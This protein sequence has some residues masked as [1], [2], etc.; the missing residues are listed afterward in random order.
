MGSKPTTTRVA[1][2]I[3]AEMARQ[4]C[5]QERLATSLGTTQ[6]FISRRLSGRVAFTVDDLARIADSLNVPMAR[7]VDNEAAA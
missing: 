3:R 2:N 4:S 1:D 5:T 6:Q 7:L